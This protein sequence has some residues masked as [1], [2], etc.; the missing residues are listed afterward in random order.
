[1]Q[2]SENAKSLMEEHEIIMEAININ[3]E[4]RKAIIISSIVEPDGADLCLLF[5]EGLETEGILLSDEAPKVGDKVYNIAAPAGIFHPPTV[6]IMHGI[7][8]GPVNDSNAM[9]TVPAIGGSSGSAIIDEDMRLVGILFATHP[10]FNTITLCS[11]YEV[12]AIFLN[13]GIKKFL[14]MKLGST[15]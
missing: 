3:N 10:G 11:T 13:E 12:M 8:S 15:N 2:L 7:F 6:P 14:A 9:V 1:M 5:V 4:K